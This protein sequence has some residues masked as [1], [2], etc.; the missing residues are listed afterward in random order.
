MSLRY[1]VVGLGN[2]GR[3]RAA[4]LGPRCVATVDPVAAEATHRTVEALDPAAYDA[5]VLATPT[6]PK[7]GYLAHFLA[8]GKP[9]LVDKP[10]LL[11]DRAE[12]EALARGARDGAIWYT[13]YNHRFEPLIVRLGELLRAGAPGPVD[14]ARLRYGNGTVRHW[15]GSWREGGGGVLEDL[16]CHLVDLCAHLLGRREERYQLWDLRSIE[17]G[18][19]DYALFSSAD[20]RVLCEVG[21][22]FWKNCFEIEVFGERGSLHLSGLGKWGGA[23]LVHRERVLPSGPP[24]E[25]VERSPAGDATWG[26]DLAEFERRVAARLGSL[27]DDW[28]VSAALAE[29]LSQ[30]GIR[31]PA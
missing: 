28:R 29:L 27:E 31:T 9:V 22:V 6:A 17:S 4:L 8:L 21:N 7:L 13:S 1:V 15:I 3:R 24:V 11:A 16:G 25:R 20:R 2:V 23:Q 5:A 26:A 14:R 19:W 30:A 10:L 18:T 12:G